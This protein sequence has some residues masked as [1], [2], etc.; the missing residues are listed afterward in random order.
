MG[1][2]QRR[3]EV[4]SGVVGERE[5]EKERERERERGTRPPSNQ[6]QACRGAENP[7]SRRDRCWAEAH[8]TG[9]G[10]QI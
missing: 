6:V 2:Y 1:I 3:A 7:L 10:G 8:G 5:K 9:C 4:Q